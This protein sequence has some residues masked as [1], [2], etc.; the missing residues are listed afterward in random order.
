MKTLHSENIISQLIKKNDSSNQFEVLKN[1]AEQINFALSQKI[2]LDKIAIGKTLNI[3][4]TGMGGSA[5]SGEVVSNLFQKK[6]EYPVFINRNYELPA[7]ANDKTLLIVSSY[8]GNTE[9]TI[10]SLKDGLRKKC[11]ICVMTTGG[12]IEIIAKENDLPIIKLQK[13]FQPRFALWV[14]LFSLLNL[15]QYLN[16]IPDISDLVEKAK[17]IIKKRANEFSKEKNL[18]LDYAVQLLGFIPVI[19]AV[20]GITGVVASR[21]KAQLNENSKIHACLNSYPELNHNEI[22]GWETQN[23]KIFNSKVVCIYDK[24][25]HP[26]I[27]KRIKITNDLIRK[28]N[29]EIIEIKSEESEYELR[30]LDLIYLTDWI[31]YYLAVLRNFDPSEINYIH[32]LKKKLSE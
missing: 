30:L 2:D 18:P 7:F 14:N 12:E 9:E 16:L 4:I 19:Y 25:Y 24:D 23:E 11:Q 27:Q 26:Q 6:L 15:F 1:S 8:S 3:I 21:F 32:F 20:D 29:T 5:I 22:I 13:G 17:I 10:S 28:A 31:S